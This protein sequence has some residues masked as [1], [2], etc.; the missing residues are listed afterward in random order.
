MRALSGFRVLT[1]VGAV[2]AA[3][4]PPTVSNDAGASVAQACADVAYARCSRIATCSS[5]AI[6]ARYG[7]E[8]AC[9][10][11]LVAFCQNDFAA[12]SS[13]RNVAKAEACA[14]AVPTWA[15][16]DDLV[17]QNPPPECQ[18]QAG[19]LGQGSPCA[20]NDQCTSARCQ[21]PPG[22]ACGACAPP[23]ATGDPCSDPADCG[24]GFSC[25]SDTSTCAPFVVAGGACGFGMPCLDGLR[26]VGASGDGGTL[27]TCQES[28]TTPGAA[29]DPAGA[30]CS[31]YA[32]LTCDTQSKQCTTA[33]FVG[34]GQPCGLVGTGVVYCTAG[35]CVGSGSTYACQA[36]SDLGGP[37]DVAAGPGCVQP[38]RCI[39]TGGAGTS[40]ACAI[41]DATKCQ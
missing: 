29:C 40:G 23:V 37:C 1:L 31:N 15:C 26:C 2:A 39:V 8:A 41:P 6:A 13:G 20:F 3:C 33:T 16:A 7:S 11:G 21:F 18:P 28:V 5:W 34:G 19:G 17:G 22:G 24:G 36:F 10:K 12:P 30:Q 25:S 9:E 14:A 27:G 38:A 35:L 4:T 32:G